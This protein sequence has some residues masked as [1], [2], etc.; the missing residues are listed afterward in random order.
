MEDELKCLFCKEFFTEPILLSCAHSYCRR[1]VVQCQQPVCHN[2]STISPPHSHSGTTTSG[3]AP[4]THLHNTTP[5]SLPSSSGASDTI[6]LCISDQDIESDKLSIISETDSGVVVSGRNSRPPSLIGSAAAHS[7]PSGYLGGHRLPSILTPSTSG[8]IVTCKA[9][10]KRTV[11]PD[12]QTVML[13]PINNALVNVIKRYHSG[14]LSARDKSGSS[15]QIYNCQLCDTE[16][17]AIANVFCEQCDIY[18]CQSCQNS[19]HPARGPLA[20]HKLVPPSARRSYRTAIGLPKDS[21]C[22]N[23]PLENLSMYCMIC[24]LAVCCQCLQETK[25]SNHDVQ[26]LDKICKTQKAELSQILQLLSEKAK[27]ATEDI[28]RLK[29][30]N[31]AISV[32]CFDFQHR[33]TVQVDSLIEQLQERK[34]KLLQY[35]EEEKE[36]KRRIFKEQIGRCTTKLSK[37]TA[38]IQFCIEVLKEPDPA[39]YLQVSSALINRATTQEFLWHK[40]MQTTPEADPE[41]ILNLDVNNLQYAI[42]TLDFAQLKAPNA[43][44]IETAECVAENNSVTIA[45][46]AQNDD[47]AI[48]GYILEIDSGSDDGLFKEVYCG[49]DTIC[50]IDG[51]H[52]NTVYNARVKAFNAAGESSYSDMICLQTAGVAW[53]QLNKSASQNDLTISN[54]CMSVTG[55]TMEYRTLCGSI[56]FSRGI[57]YWEVTVERHA[58]NADVV[59]GVAQNAFNRGIMLGKDLHGWSM[60]IDGERSW[61]LHN[62]MHHSR[63]IGGI[64]VGS[65]IGILLDCDKGTLAFFVNDTRRNY[66][67]QL[68]A[69]RNMPH[70]LYYP[71]FSV[72][73]DTLITVHTGLP[74]PSSSGSSDC[75]DT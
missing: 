44:L 56:A 8:W 51:L 58:G 46:K 18:Y 26:S 63:I 2:A 74:I 47:C 61:Y 23:H 60:Y 31:D 67:G 65:V 37:T 34:Q 28:T 24:R 15:E 30:L 4:F 75:S 7:F 29:Q 57:H 54:E 40:E 20:S 9:C 41:F 42:Q 25:H 32:N 62:G 71:A 16:E 69:F 39:T 6:S 10:Y 52:F 22:P 68:V 21:K 59:V 19:L 17:P 12:E 55:T 43:P 72:N 14:N 49:R 11:F 36:F 38:L 5:L 48:D 13:M 45:W 70:G 50:T 3:T 33:L 53:F 35:V 27:H 66:E 1:C 64:S 73:C